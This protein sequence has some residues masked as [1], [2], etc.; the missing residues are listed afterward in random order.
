MDDTAHTAATPEEPKRARSRNRWIV[1]GTAIAALTVAGIIGAVLLV[2]RDDTP[3]D[4]TAQIGWMQDGCQQWADGYQGASGPDDD[5][6]NSMAGWMN[7]RTGDASMMDR[8]QMMG[9]MIWQSADN[10]P[11]T[12]E[13]WMADTP[14]AV[15][16]GV[17]TSGWCEQMTNWM[18]QNMGDWD[19]WMTNGPR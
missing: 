12:C 3:D 5:W 4:A 16:D 18:D 1:I 10:M 11:A 2:N 17:D 19:S 15:P 6:C 7:G 13:Q 8:G 9:P 14:D